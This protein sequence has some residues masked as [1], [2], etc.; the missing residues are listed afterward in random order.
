VDVDRHRSSTVQF[1]PADPRNRRDRIKVVRI[2][3]LEL[4]RL[5]SSTTLLSY[6]VA[7]DEEVD[8]VI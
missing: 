6:K 8:R 3:V 5:L 7:S 1:E 4:H 2:D